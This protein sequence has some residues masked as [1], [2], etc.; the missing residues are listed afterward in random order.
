MQTANALQAAPEESSVQAPAFSQALA[1]RGGQNAS[2]FTSNAVA[3][4]PPTVA[5]TGNHALTVAMRPVAVGGGMLLS[6][7][8]HKLDSF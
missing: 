6:F 1:T 7:L 4:R 8:A 3:M 2:A 5:A